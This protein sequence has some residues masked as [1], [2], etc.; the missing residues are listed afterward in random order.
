MHDVFHRLVEQLTDSSDATD[1][2]NALAE[3]ASSLD[4]PSFA[5]LLPPSKSSRETRL[6]STYPRLWTSHYLHSGYEHVDP[7][8]DQARH[9]QEPFS[10]CSDDCDLGMSKIQQQFMNEATCFG[11][12]SGFTIP[13]LD[14]HGLFASLTFASDELRPLFLRLIDR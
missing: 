10:W 12:R 6:I 11:I 7:V 2:R 4:L 5:Y 3:T 1:L 13:I 9:R 14:R 8:V